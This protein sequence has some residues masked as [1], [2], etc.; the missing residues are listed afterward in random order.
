MLRQL[1]SIFSK[2][3]AISC[4]SV[5][6]NARPRSE[7]RK[8]WLP[9]K[10]PPKVGEPQRVRASLCENASHAKLLTRS[11]SL[12][13]DFDEIKKAEPVFTSSAVYFWGDFRD[14]LN[15]KNLA[16]ARI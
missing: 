10:Y 13:F 14:F 9:P 4:N 2:R 16:L 7:R 8:F 1:V 3:G 5:G 12:V 6:T 11:L 15:I